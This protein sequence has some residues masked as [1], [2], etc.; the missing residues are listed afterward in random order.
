MG[1]KKGIMDILLVAAAVKGSSSR[2][3]LAPPLGL[4]YIAS[5][6]LKAG[7]NISAIDFNI[8]GFDPLRVKKILERDA[9][10]IL[11]ISAHTETYLSGLKIA[12]IAKQVNPETIV[13][14]GGAHPSVMYQEAAEDKNIDVVV[15]GEGEYAMLELADYFL[16]N[17]GNLAQIKGIAY[18]ENGVVRTTPERPFVKDPDE[19][20]FPARELFPLPL[21]KVSGG[22]LLSRGGCPFHCRYCAVNNIWQGKRRFRKPEKVVEEILYILRH[23]QAQEINFSDDTFTLDRQRV[24]ELCDLLKALKEPFQ[25][26]W[27]CSTRVDLVD[28]ELLEKMYEAGCYGIQYGIEAGSQKIL[29]SIGKGITLEQVRDAVSTSLDVGMEVWCFF[30]FPHPEDTE[31]TVR[32]QIRLMQELKRMGVTESMTS[33]TPFPGTYYYDH[34]D[35]LGIKILTDSWDEFHGRHLTITT[36]HLSKENLESLLDE[37]AHDVGMVP[38]PGLEP[39]S[40]NISP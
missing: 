13:V 27:V 1:E 37:I 35:E 26:R 3:R 24:I 21:Y 28:R 33:T 25:V 36:K 2:A 5:V 32:E 19:L 30:M 31:E 34:A 9:P 29:D 17:K 7:Y 11:G 10:R 16:K 15:R 22:V 18:R 39:L 4:A 12:E 14:I 38:A 8:S 23:G 40:D 6:L 20:P